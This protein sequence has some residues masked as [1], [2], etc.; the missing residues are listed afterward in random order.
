MATF[1]EAEKKQIWELFEL[2][3]EELH[4][5]SSFR[6]ALAQTESDDVTYSTD[7]VGDVKYLLTEITTLQDTTIPAEAAES[8]YEVIDIDD[9]YRVQIKDG[10]DPANY[11]RSQLTGKVERIRTLLQLDRYS[12]QSAQYAKVLGYWGANA[13]LGYHQ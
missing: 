2:E 12:L 6:Q 1:T 4:P 3:R 11:S 13:R 8:A 7:I 10:G 5:N 9:D